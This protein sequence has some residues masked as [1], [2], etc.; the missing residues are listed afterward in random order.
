MRCA[1]HLALMAQMRHANKFWLENQKVR[2]HLE[3][4]GIDGGIISGWFLMRR[5][6]LD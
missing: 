2:N 5:C 1:M 3:D 6:E 4:L